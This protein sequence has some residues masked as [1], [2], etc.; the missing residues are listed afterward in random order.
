MTTTVFVFAV[1]VP[2]GGAV[3]NV[4]VFVLARVVEARILPAGTTGKA[5]RF[6]HDVLAT[7]ASG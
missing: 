5:I 3:F 6:L 1:A 7:S 2:F 4:A